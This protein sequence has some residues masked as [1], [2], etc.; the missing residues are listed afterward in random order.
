MHGQTQ[1]MWDFLETAFRTGMLDELLNLIH[2]FLG[3][4]DQDMSQKFA[5]L[6]EWFLERDDFTAVDRTFDKIYAF[7][8]GMTD[9]DTMEGLGILLSFLSPLIKSI[10]E[11]VPSDSGLSGETQAGLEEKIIKMFKALRTI[12]S[13]GTKLYVSSL[14]EKP[15]HEIGFSVGKSL[16]SVSGFINTIQG[17]NA[18]VVPDF[19]SGVFSSIDGNAVG[20]MAET[21]TEGLLD[22]KPPIFR[23]AA[24]TAAKRA[25]KRF[26][27]K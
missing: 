6:E 17:E 8:Q 22:Q 3:E 23:W 1:I 19:M 7:M 21:L 15:A 5:D 26:L 25:R 16:N 2:V 27:N 4:G 20:K 14:G 18:D 13:L 24:A 12:V 11:K 9:A 10:M